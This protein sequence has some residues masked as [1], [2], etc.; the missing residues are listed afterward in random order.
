[1]MSVEQSVEWEVA[2]ETEV[3]G[4]NLRQRHLGHHKYYV[5]RPELEP[6]PLW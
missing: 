5:T 2:G 4:E 3:F 1:M 6:G